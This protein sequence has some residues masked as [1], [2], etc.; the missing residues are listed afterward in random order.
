MLLVC[1]WVG[2][3]ADVLLGK[4]K[5]RGEGVESEDAGDER[6]VD[7]RSLA[8]AEMSALESFEETYHGV[9][10]MLRSPYLHRAATKHMF[11]VG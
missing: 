4:K 2:I 3:W 8:P 1:R 11:S 6:T 7:E 9:E 10:G 5:K